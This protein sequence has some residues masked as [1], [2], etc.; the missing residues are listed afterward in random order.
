MLDNRR[1]VGIKV[2]NLG[3]RGLDTYLP[4]NMD[5]PRIAPDL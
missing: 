3:G 4:I 1:C 2:N 5:D